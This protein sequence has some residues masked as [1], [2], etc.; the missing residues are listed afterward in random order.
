LF[1]IENLGLGGAING[2][3]AGGLSVSFASRFGVAVGRSLVVVDLD[4]SAVATG[5]GDGEAMALD[6]GVG[7]ASRLVVS[8]GRP[9]VINHA[10]RTPEAA[11][12]RTMANT[13]GNAL[14]LESIRLP[15]CF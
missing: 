3:G 1:S 14:L 6:A 4:V 15:L 2:V 12:T 5:D 13:Q 8:S 9:R 7:P 10:I 11:K